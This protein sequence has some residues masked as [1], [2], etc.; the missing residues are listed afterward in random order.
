MLEIDGGSLT[1]DDNSGDTFG[2]FSAESSG[3]VTIFSRS[4]NSKHTRRQ[5]N[6]LRQIF[7]RPLDSF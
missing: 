5:E 6:T 4:K 2:Y 1:L 3:D 7:D